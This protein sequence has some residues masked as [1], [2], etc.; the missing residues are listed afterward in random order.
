MA[1]PSPLSGKRVVITRAD[2][3]SAALAGALR[4]K[5]A[6][7]VS[8]PLIRIAPP[9]DYAR[10]DSA[11]RCL[12]SFD[13]LLFTSQNAVT[14]VADR[15]AALGIQS[16]DKSLQIAAVGRSTSDAATAVGFLVTSVGKG[17]TAADLIR[18]LAH[19]FRGKRIFLPRSDRAASAP[20]AQLRDLGAI[21]TEVIAY[22]T[23]ALD[24]VLSSVRDAVVR[25]DA[26][27][28]LS[29]SAVNAF[30]NLV[31]SG[32][33][34]VRADIAVGAIGPVTQAAVREAGLRCDFQASEPAISE[35]VAALAAHFVTTRVSSVS[36]VNSR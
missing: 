26:V 10:L 17:G 6:E 1:N 28:F 16:K 34:S 24:S 21:V 5:G 27:L 13:W 11:L 22:Q 4:E 31:R 23:I 12:S 29:P 14:A 7:V 32:V 9:P 33:L 20:I 30:L 36:G 25:S 35:I 8:L 18:E 19:D 15:L 3:Q 2:S